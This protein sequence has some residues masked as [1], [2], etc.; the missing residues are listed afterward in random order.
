MS[1]DPEKETSESSVSDVIPEVPATIPVPEPV[2]AV[3]EENSVPLD[4]PSPLLLASSIILAIVS[5]GRW[6]CK[7]Q[8]AICVTFL[9]RFQGSLFDLIG[10]NDN[11]PK[12]I[13]ALKFIPQA[14]G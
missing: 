1:S 3:E 6:T 4:L 12:E 2:Q 8:T 7:K 5:T 11:E 10:Y 14:A 9:N 13:D